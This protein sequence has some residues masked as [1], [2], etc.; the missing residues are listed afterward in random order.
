M[1]LFYIALS[2]DYYSLLDQDGQVYGQSFDKLRHSI[3]GY[4]E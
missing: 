1:Q 3:G 4:H 2:V